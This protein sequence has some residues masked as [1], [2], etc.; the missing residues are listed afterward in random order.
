MEIPH[1]PVEIAAEIALF[2]LDDPSF[3]KDFQP[4]RE[5]E[6][7]II[8]LDETADKAKLFGNWC[9]DARLGF[10]IPKSFDADDETEYMRFD[11]LY[12][13]GNFACYSRVAIGVLDEHAV[14]AIC[15]AFDKGLLVLPEFASIE[16]DHL[17]HIPVLAVQEMIRQET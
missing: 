8:W 12:F 4:T 14:R 10:Q 11:G 1:N 17:L 5:E 16:D 7:D 6:I 15:M 9:I 2:R 3:G 13:E